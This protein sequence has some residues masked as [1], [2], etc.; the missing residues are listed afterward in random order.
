MWDE[1][2]HQSDILSVHFPQGPKPNQRASPTRTEPLS[3]SSTLVASTFLRS[4]KKATCLRVCLTFD[5]DGYCVLNVADL[6]GGGAD[7]FTRIIERGPW[8]LN[9]LVEVLHFHG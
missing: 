4:E 3:D 8:D 6:I 9:H 7:V 1:E 2:R 5:P